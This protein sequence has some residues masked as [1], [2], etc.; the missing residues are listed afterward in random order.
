MGELVENL[1]VPG[2]WIVQGGAVGLLAVVALMIFLGLLVPARTYKAL[3][4][5]RNYWR[6]AAMKSGEQTK[7]LMSAARIT[8]EFTRALAGAT[9]VHPGRDTSDEVGPG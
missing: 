5:D 2:S 6:D 8:A 9:G 4:R 3:E 7:D 1:P